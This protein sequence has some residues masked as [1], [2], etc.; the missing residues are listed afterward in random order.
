MN[1]VSAMHSTGEIQTSQSGYITAVD[2]RYVAAPAIK[3]FE[4]YRPEY[5]QGYACRYGKPL[6]HDG[7]FKV[8]TAG[9]FAESIKDKHYVRVLIN[10][11]DGRCVGSN[12][13]D[14]LELLTDKFGIAFRF[15]L[16]DSD[17]GRE[18]RS[19][20]ETNAMTGVSVGFNSCRTE[21][22][23]I[24]GTPVVFLSDGILYEISLVEKGACA[25]A[26]A[27]LVDAESCGR[28]ADDCLQFPLRLLV[29]GSYVDMMRHLR[30]LRDAL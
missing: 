30:R 28:L 6:F 14:E 4:R 3:T 19:L 24:D 22:K 27:M 2:G 23:Q 12:H 18:M 20:I 29:E 7:K 15:K 21:T 8:L 10:H 11:D 1:F 26:Y 9:T 17:L 25:S 5:V 13:D 16:P